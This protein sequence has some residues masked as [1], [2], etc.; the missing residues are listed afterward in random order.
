MSPVSPVAFP[1]RISDLGGS[2]E[3]I[4]SFIKRIDSFA[5]LENRFQKEGN[6]G[7]FGQ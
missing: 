1:D 3:E 7:G 5:V 4:N 2:S 6:E